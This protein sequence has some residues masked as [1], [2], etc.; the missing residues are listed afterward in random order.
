MS[1]RLPRYRT[2]NPDLDR[3]V[4][5][6]LDAT[7]VTENRDQLFEIIVTAVRLAGDGADRLD[8][9]ITNAAL[10]E[11]RSAFRTFAPVPRHPEGDDVRLGPHP[12]ARSAVRAGAATWPRRWPAGGGWS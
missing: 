9:K 4:L 1:E 7:G 8:L 12:A 10:K 5:E 3:R 2:G 11:M 6:L